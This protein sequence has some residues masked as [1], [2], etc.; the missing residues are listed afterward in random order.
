MD[1]N[2]N[3]NLKKN[4]KTVKDT[5]FFHK[6]PPIKLDTGFVNLERFVA[7]NEYDDGSFSRE[8]NCD[9]INRKGSDAVIIVPYAYIDNQINVLMISTFRPVVYYREK[10][11]TEKNPE[12]I[13]EHIMKFLEFPAGML[14]EEEMN[15][16]N[17]NQGVKKCAQRELEEETGYSVPL[18]NINVLG[19]RYY[20]SSG[21]I[22]E[23]INIATC[24]IT[25][26]VPKKDIKTDG[27]VMEETIESFFVPFNKAI[28]WCKEGIIKN[29]GTEIGLNRLYFSILYEHQKNHNL[30]LQKRLHTLLNE[31]NSLKKS[32]EHYNKLIREFKA[33]V[34][35]ELRHPFTEIMGY[36]N[37]LKKN[38]I[39]EERREEAFNIV[40]RS[41]KKLYDT[42]NNLIQIALKDD[43]N[44]KYVSEFNVEDEINIIVEGYKFIYPKDIKI[45]INIE[46]NCSI[47]IGYHERFR[48]I[49]EGII[50]NAFKFT[51]SGTISINVRT[52]DTIEKK[53]LDFSPDLFNYHTMQNIIPN[54]IEIMVKD[55][56]KGIKQSQLKKIFIPFY[57]GDSRFE[58][59]YGGIGIGLSVVKDLL[60]TMQG[61]INIDSSEGAGTIVKLRMPFGIPAKN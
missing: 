8:Y 36:I 34:S 30:I 61:A 16:K 44:S 5:K 10:V 20:S 12:N 11:M 18:K 29:A 45:E 31:I 2:D 37:L 4:I 27:S 39:T 32:A 3:K 41:V 42:N 53:A 51:K 35:H 6:S 47:L 40:S 22:T 33:T 21:I 52:L 19:H 15:D 49:M 1:N 13:D 17:P 50:S 55:T 25:G 57:Q 26:I 7:I 54:E 60:D 58:R 24:D 56:G 23:R 9:I 46:K 43:E 38:N 28:E 48:L 59:E 14:E